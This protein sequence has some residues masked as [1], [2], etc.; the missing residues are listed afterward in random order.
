MTTNT[1]PYANNI[2]LDGFYNLRDGG[3]LSVPGGRVASRRL[4]RSDQPPHL[5]PKA[6]EFFKSLPLCQVIDLRS[7]EEVQEAPPVW[8]Q[9]GFKVDHVDMLS[10][11]IKSMMN[12]IPSLASLYTDM[13]NNDGKQLAEAVGAVSDGVQDGAVVVHCT[14]GKDR[15]GVVIALCQELLGVPRKEI[16][17]NYTA[18][19]ANLSGG[20]LEGIAKS[21]AAKMGVNL[22]E[23]MSKVA[24]SGTTTQQ[25]EELATASPASAIESALDLI[26][27]SH[28][29]VHAY[30]K[31]NGLS[32]ERIDA[33]V[34]ALVEK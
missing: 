19:H 29:G 10:G 33:L 23:M 7:A 27:Q 6:V 20:W 15:T 25:I 1:D 31:A 11:S 16:I 3:D 21:Y 17:G 2:P 30:L 4:L 8:T 13:I 34:S 5:D 28:G 18:T 22:Q 32:Q 9:A 24:A 12:N 14:A 26:D